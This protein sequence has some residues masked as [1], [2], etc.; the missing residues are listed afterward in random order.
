MAIV[1]LTAL[2]LVRSVTS[3]DAVADAV[4]HL[5]RVYGKR[6]ASMVRRL[7]RLLR[8]HFQ[9]VPTPSQDSVRACLPEV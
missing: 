8:L 2:G 1:R 9:L 6:S 4:K 5:H 7:K 3:E